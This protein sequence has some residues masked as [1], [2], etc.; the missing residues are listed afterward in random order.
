PR[1][2]PH[3]VWALGQGRVGEVLGGHPIVP[4]AVVVAL[5]VGPA[6]EGGFGEDLFLD[7][8]ELAE[9]NLGFKGV[10]FLRQLLRNRIAELFFPVCGHETPPA[11]LLYI[12]VAPPMAILLL[13]YRNSLEIFGPA[14]KMLLD[15]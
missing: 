13:L 12:L 5:P 2:I 7:L 14:L 15:P 3:G 10:D 9:G 11:A 6:A 4:M 8:P 1:R